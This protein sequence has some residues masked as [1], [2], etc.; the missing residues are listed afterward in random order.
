MSDTSSPLSSVASSP[1][2]SEQEEIE[3]SAS[4]LPPTSATT[5]PQ[6][7]S[8]T[9]SEQSSD[10]G[11]TGARGK[12]RARDEDDESY[13]EG[14]TKKKS[15]SVKKKRQLAPSTDEESAEETIPN[16]AKETLTSN[17]KTAPGSKNQPHKAGAATSTMKKTSSVGAAATKSI[18]KPNTPSASN[19]LHHTQ[20]KS[21]L[22]PA[23]ASKDKA[24]LPSH[25]A[26]PLRS[27]NLAKRSPNPTTT[28]LP[29]T[30]VAGAKPTPFP[31]AR[32]L[33]SAKPKPSQS[34]LS[35]AMQAT[36]KKPPVKSSM[37]MQNVDVFESLFNF[38]PAKSSPK[39]HPT[40]PSAAARAADRERERGDTKSRLREG[41]ST[42]AAASNDQMEVDA[43]KPS[44]KSENARNQE[45][46][47]A[48]ISPS[49][50][51]DPP[52][53]DQT[54]ADLN[55]IKISKVKSAPAIAE[56]PQRRQEAEFTTQQKLDK[57]YS[58]IPQAATK[59]LLQT[60]RREA[61]QL[62]E[63]L[64]NGSL[65][66]MR[67]PM[68]MAQLEEEFKTYL[69]GL[70]DPLPT[71][72]FGIQILKGIG[73]DGDGQRGGYDHEYG[74]GKQ[75]RDSRGRDPWTA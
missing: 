37:D 62:H 48:Q 6:T 15:Q 49:K 7:P 9:P 60:T 63:E 5:R 58:G 73:R 42:V 74:Y 55:A 3:G 21:S 28:K 4:P 40:T 11:T 38:G 17:R 51:A 10:S 24:S 69:R 68:E 12:K 35:A 75:G 47:T 1:P 29:S 59:D 44:E 23:T 8:P 66:L 26:L 56:K 31:S 57:L 27:S 45:T 18:S 67:M 16:K 39:P 65:D 61:R 53:Y 34:G 22:A 33:P 54:T 36:A 50:P 30:T 72:T 70:H 52:K 64:K 41:I 71:G 43:M 19:S 13:D 20:K 2:E 32:S 25:Q 14:Q 46:E